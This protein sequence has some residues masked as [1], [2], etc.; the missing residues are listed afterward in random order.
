M[1]I[2]ID[3]SLVVGLVARDHRSDLISTTI[4]RWLEAGENLHAPSLM[5]FEVA[6]GLT[7]LVHAGAVPSNQVEDR[8]TKA[9]GLPIRLHP[10]ASGIR[11][12]EIALQ[13]VRKSAYDAAY[14]ALAEQ[15]DAELW[16]LDRRLVN[17]ASALD[18]RI[19]LLE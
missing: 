5:P 8:W 3:A 6:S 4:L 11:A 16:T 13:L 14:L 12:V 15:L 1:A 7:R 19:H 18:F 2:V 17:A 9:I 10:L